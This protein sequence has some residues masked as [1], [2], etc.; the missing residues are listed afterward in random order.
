MTT[1]N[2][3][4]VID[5]A[6]NH[7]ARLVR[8]VPDDVWTAP[9]PCTEWDV[10]ALVNHVVAEHLWVPPLLG[11]VSI[12]E[13]GSKY[14]G[15]VLGDDP[16]GA[17]DA[18]WAA[19]RAAW[20]AVDEDSTVELSRGVTPIAD[21][22][23]ELIVDLVVHG[24]DLSRGAGLDESADPAT[25]A[26]ALEISEQLIDGLS[27]SGAYGPSVPVQSDDPMTRLVALL[28]RHP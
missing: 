20:A 19:S 28:G 11:G 21:Y 25:A 5:Q 15:D 23:A 17:S 24:W 12:E 2:D 9:T 26:R 6:G 22:R 16:V 10:R 27:G 1:S 13:V 8:E 14:D 3:R 4:A 7:F 18:A